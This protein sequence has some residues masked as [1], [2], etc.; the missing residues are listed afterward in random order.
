MYSKF[1]LAAKFEYTSFL[2]RSVCVLSRLGLLGVCIVSVYQSS[3]MFQLHSASFPCSQYKLW[4]G[5]L[6]SI[7]SSYFT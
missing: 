2:G 1:D 5:I 6:Q 7:H 3:A 4:R